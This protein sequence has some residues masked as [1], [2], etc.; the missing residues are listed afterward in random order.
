MD[1]SLFTIFTIVHFY[2]KV[3]LFV[4]AVCCYF[5]GLECFHISRVSTH[6]E[7]ERKK[8]VTHKNNKIMFQSAK[9]RRHLIVGGCFPLFHEQML[10]PLICYGLT[11]KAAD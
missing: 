5:Y 8:M 9:D 10:I 4:E 1:W 11:D 6:R 2:G 3:N 7:R